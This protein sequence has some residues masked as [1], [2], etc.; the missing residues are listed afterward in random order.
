MG[1]PPRW[2]VLLTRQAFRFT[3]LSGYTYV[4]SKQRKKFI[5]VDSMSSRKKLRTRA[6]ACAALYKY[7]IFNE[8]GKKTKRKAWVKKWRLDRDRYGHMPLLRELRDNDP[9]DYKNYL[10]MD[11]TTF[12]YLLNLVSPYIAKQDTVMR[13]CIKAEERLA[14][15]LR[16]V[17]TGRSLQ[18]LKFS[19]CI[20]ASALCHIIPE[21]CC[22]IYTALKKDY[23]KVSVGYQLFYWKNHKYSI[24]QS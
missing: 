9:E 19:T 24:Y 12:E 11:N 6:I 22:S 1:F 7:I 20:S 5:F 18:D 23:L 10:R 4:V 21:T 8:E 16:F 2:K 15:T 13:N 14:A 17:A 3:L